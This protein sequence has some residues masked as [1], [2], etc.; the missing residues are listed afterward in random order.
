MGKSMTRLWTVLLGSLLSTGCPYSP[1]DS[2]GQLG[3]GGGPGGP[4]GAPKGG[5]PETPGAFDLSLVT[6]RL[7]QD[8]IRQADHRTV[9]GSVEGECPG[10]LRIDVIPEDAGVPPLPEDG[11]SAGGPGGGTA[12]PEPVRPLTMLELTAT[13]PFSLVVPAGSSGDLAVVCDADK[14]N[15]IKPD[16][17][18]LS[19]RR[20]LGVVETDL[21]GVILKLVPVMALGP[22]GGS[23]GGQPGAGGPAG[24]APGMGPAGPDGKGPPGPPASAPGQ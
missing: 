17:D 1:S 13:G 23:A 22:S 3:P 19:E 9:S 24:A 6:P 5:G 14:D 2:P 12:R 15:L 10:T 8:E 7:T 16:N 18:F 11:A 21:D 20:A 4:K